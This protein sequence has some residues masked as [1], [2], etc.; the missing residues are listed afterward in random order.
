MSLACT[1]NLF[2]V[3]KR[4]LQLGKWRTWSLNHHAHDAVHKHIAPHSWNTSRT[5]FGVKPSWCKLSNSWKCLYFQNVSWYERNVHL[6]PTRRKWCVKQ[7]VFFL[8]NSDALFFFFA[9]ELLTVKRS[10]HHN[11]HPAVNRGQV[12]QKPRSDCQPK[13]D[14]FC[15]SDH[16]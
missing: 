10:A 8:T 9:A 5:H 13:S 6:L 12:G 16:I 15:K 7:S 2:C 1:R 14:F 11:R 4:T 3:L